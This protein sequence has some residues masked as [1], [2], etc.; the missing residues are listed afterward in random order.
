MFKRTSV[1]LWSLLFAF[2]TVATVAVAQDEKSAEETKKEAKA[3]PEPL[4]FE[5]SHRLQSGGTDI[6]YTVTAEDIYLRDAEGEPTA[7]FFTISYAKAGVENP[8]DRPV[9]FI[10]NGGPGSSSIW[11]HFGL[12]GPKLIDIPSDASDPGGPPYRLK[13]NPWTI[14]RATD[15]V[16]VDPVGTGFSKPLG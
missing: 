13:D 15:L 1:I 8:E 5:S 4:K 14:L 6:S 12:V 16:F 10:F 9:T 7:S 11:L 3:P 2:S